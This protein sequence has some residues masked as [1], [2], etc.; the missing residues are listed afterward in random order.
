MREAIGKIEMEKVERSREAVR[1][2]NWDWK[3]SGRSDGAMRWK[4]VRA[5]M[6]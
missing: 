3:G 5:A 2:E 1:F 4:G 6:E